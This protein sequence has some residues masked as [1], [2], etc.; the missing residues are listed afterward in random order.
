MKI[1][2]KLIVIMFSIL[3]T[4]MVSFGFISYSQ[5]KK[6]MY[7]M[8]DQDQKQSTIRLENSLV[9]PLW[10]FDVDTLNLLLNI[11]MESSSI[12]AIVVDDGLEIFGKIRLEDSSVGDFDPSM[13]EAL[14]KQ[15]YSFSEGVIKSKDESIGEIGTLVVYSSDAEARSVLYGRGIGIFV[16]TLVLDILIV[17]AIAVSFFALIRKPLN[18][19][20]EN[21][22]SIAQGEGDLTQKIFFR[23]RDEVGELAFWF[24]LFVDNLNE[25]VTHVKSASS[26]NIVIKER[27][28]NTSSKGVETLNIITNSV[29]KIQGYAQTLD[30]R[31]ADSN[32]VLKNT[33]ERLDTLDNSVS[34]EIAAVEETSA[35]VN[36]M[37]ASLQ[38]VAGITKKRLEGIEDLK[39]SVVIG[40]EKLDVMI[41]IVEKIYNNIGNISEMVSLINNISSQTNLLAMN[42]AIEAAHAGEAGKGFAVVADEIRKLAESS[43]KSAKGIS[44]ILHGIIEDIKMASSESE[45]TKSSFAIIDSSISEIHKALTEIS[46]STEELSTGSQQINQSTAMLN[47]IS[48]D[49]RDATESLK[50]NN[51]TL[52]ESMNQ[53]QQIADDVF[54]GMNEITEGNETIEHIVQD[55]NNLAEE[56]DATS[57]SMHSEV[58][59]FKT[60]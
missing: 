42:A 39:N 1:Y 19:I 14:D 32:K 6:V 47:S 38:N 11:E 54:D 57:N 58:S 7:E 3:T 20:G 43:N 51:H 26:Q 12:L 49:L 22:Q 23:N 59:R 50:L 48:G 2:L 60:A 46:L 9:E 15:A 31:I 25:I 8:L 28:N 34:D 21:I 30:E 18:N 36:Q 5:Q 17:L 40:G 13:L 24:N 44:T 56:L 37:V 52:N 33:N 27:L 4:I 16:Q 35:S 29:Q 53:V 41:A 45:E 55:L 10:N